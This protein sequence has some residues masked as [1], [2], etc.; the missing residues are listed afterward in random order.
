[1]PLTFC[2]NVHLTGN[3]RKIL[4]TDANLVQ[5][6]VMTAATRVPLEDL[7]ER[8]LISRQIT[9]L[10]RYQLMLVFLADG[11]GEGE[12]ILIDRLLYGVRKGLLLVVD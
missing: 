6:M 1:M 2:A 8:I 7:V 3:T 10:S 12:H 5:L 4:Q 11:L 9:P